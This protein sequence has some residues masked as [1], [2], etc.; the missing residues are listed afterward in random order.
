MVNAN[1]S[2]SRK[3]ASCIGQVPGSGFIVVLWTEIRRDAGDVEL[4]VRDLDEFQCVGEWTPQGSRKCAP[5]ALRR[6]IVRRNREC[7][8]PG[9]IQI[10]ECERVRVREKKVYVRRSP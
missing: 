6:G 3:R 1:W 7:A 10:I 9:N 2:R 4:S 8:A 5:R